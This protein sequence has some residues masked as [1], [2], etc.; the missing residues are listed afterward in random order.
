MACSAMR[1]QLTRKKEDKGETQDK[2]VL[3][4]DNAQIF[5]RTL[6][7]QLAAGT[8]ER[9]TLRIHRNSRNAFVP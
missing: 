4:T 3:E 7:P 1:S 8:L 5:Q 2:G 9:Q 6:N